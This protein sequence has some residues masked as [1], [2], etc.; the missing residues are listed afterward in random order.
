ME[1]E[2]VPVG[3]STTQPLSAA[4]TPVSLIKPDEIHRLALEFV[5][6]RDYMPSTREKALT[7]IQQWYESGMPDG[8]RYRDLLLQC[9]LARTTIGSRFAI[10]RNFCEFLVQRGHASVNSFRVVVVRGTQQE[11]RRS[12]S[13]EEIRFILQ[14]ARENASVRDY[15]LIALMAGTGL[16]TQAICGLNFGDY[17]SCVGYVRLWVRHKGRWA[18]DRYV[19]IF[20]GLQAVLENWLRVRPAPRADQAPFFCTQS[21]PPRRMANRSVRQVVTRLMQ[22]AGFP[23]VPHQLRHTAITLARQLGAPL[24]SV[25]EMAGHAS[26]ITTER[27]DHSLQRELFPP[28]RVIDRA[29]YER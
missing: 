12:F 3:Q 11:T 7:F 23:G 27:Y 6:E 9:G 19:L 16:R 26:V 4:P 24:E 28:E 8:V 2:I 5:T 20:P 14:Y 22:R 15:A 17:E 18:K 29:L 13:L 10:L 21:R 1:N 25:R